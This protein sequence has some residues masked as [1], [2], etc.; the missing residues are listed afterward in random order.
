MN[1]KVRKI[2][3]SAVLANILALIGNIIAIVSIIFSAN[4]YVAVKSMCNVNNSEVGSLQNANVI[5]NNGAS[6]NEIDSLYK[7]I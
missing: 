2:M 5:N 3:E 7:K 6:L 4:T 1:E